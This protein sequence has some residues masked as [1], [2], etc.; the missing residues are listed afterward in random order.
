LLC[1]ITFG[2]RSVHLAH[3]VHKSGRKT[4]TGEQKQKR[5]GDADTKCQTIVRIMDQLQPHHGPCTTPE[6]VDALFAT[7]GSR[8]NQKIVVR[9]E[10][11]FEKYVTGEHW[12]PAPVDQKPPDIPWNM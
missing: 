10:L 9:A 8:T 6:H 11:K 5:P 7:F 2:G 12:Q 1:L 4:S 3:L